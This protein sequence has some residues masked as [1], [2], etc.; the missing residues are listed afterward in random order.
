[1]DSRGLVEKRRLVSKREGK[2]GRK[3]REVHRDGEEG[4]N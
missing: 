1:M 4:D 2:K 3:K